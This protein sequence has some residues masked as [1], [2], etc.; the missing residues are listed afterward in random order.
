MTKSHP[1]RFPVPYG[2]STGC[3]AGWTRRQGLAGLGA[4]ALTAALAGLTPGRAAAQAPLGLGTMAP[5]TLSYSTGVTVAE[6][7]A[8]SLDLDTRVQPNSGESVLMA[9]LDQGDLDFAIGNAL[10]VANA[11]GG[12]GPFD[13]RPASNLRLVAALFP[14]RVGLYVRADGPLQTVADLRARRVTAGF[15]ASPAIAQLLRAALAGGGLAPDQIEPVP[16]PDLVA[17]A[18]RFLAGQVDAFFFATGAAKV[19]EVN[20]AVPLR[21]LPL[22]G[23]AAAQDRVQAVFADAF[24]DTVGPQPGLVGVAEATPMLSFDNLLVSH[25]AMPDAVVTRLLG[26]LA[27]QRQAL[28]ERFAPLRAMDPDRMVRSDLSTPY[29]PA[30]LAWHAAR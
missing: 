21:L 28:G 22:Q 10:E 18:D 23:D 30:A 29:H 3:T 5:G 12:A 13:G 27:E 15:A 11:V 8:T 2:I 1:A 14:L 19:V 9:L 20:A 26:G 24:V 4:V 25:A 16:V 7:M 17:G 6:M